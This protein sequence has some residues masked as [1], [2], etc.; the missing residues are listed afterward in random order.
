MRPKLCRQKYNLRKNVH[1]L[2]ISHCFNNDGL[3]YKCCVVNCRSNYTGEESTTVFSF[4]KEEELK[5]RWMTFVNRKDWEPT[6]SSYICTKHFEEKYYE[7]G[8]NSK[9]YRLAMNMKPV[10][11]ILDPKKVI[12]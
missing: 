1:K 3:V 2:T 6:S 11:T 9:R 7:K 12:N 5:K 4:R 10:A 8:K